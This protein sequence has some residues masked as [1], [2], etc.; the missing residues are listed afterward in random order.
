MKIAV[1]I[2]S[3][4]LA[5]AFLFAGGGKLLTPASDFQLM[6]P[7]VPV[8]LMKLAGAAEVPD[9]IGLILP[10]ATRIMPVLT[11]IA[12]AGLVLTMVGA[13][14]TDIAIGQPASAV[15]PVVLGIFAALVAFARFGPYAVEPRGAIRSAT[16]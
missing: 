15:L 7:G 6:A 16:V 5:I 10:A 1:W 12:A 8:V 11:P 14:I 13:T 3:A 4:L 2:A 9:A